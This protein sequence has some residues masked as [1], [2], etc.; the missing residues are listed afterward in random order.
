ML[1]KLDEKIHFPFIQFRQSE[2]K[3]LQNENAH[4]V[5]GIASAHSRGNTKTV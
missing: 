4:N 2:L 5:I 3:T 1:R